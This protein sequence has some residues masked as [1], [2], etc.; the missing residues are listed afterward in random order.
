MERDIE[1]LSQSW[2]DAPDA[3][4]TVAL[5]N[6]M[7]GPVHATLIQQVGDFARNNLASNVPVLI[8]V[9]RMYMSAQR[10]SEAQGTLVTAGKLAPRD[11]AVYRVL[12]ECLLRRGDADRSEKVLE[13]AIHFGANDPETRLWLERSRVFKPMQAKAGNRAVA[14]EIERT[15]PAGTN[16]AATTSDDQPPPRAQ[17]DSFPDQ[18]TEVKE[19]QLPKAAL[20][21]PGTA[22]APGKPAP[23][24]KPPSKA[25]PPPIPGGNH[26]GTG[27]PMTT[28]ESHP[29]DA[30][31]SLGAR[32][33]TQEPATN[34]K[35]SSYSKDADTASI[36]RAALPLVDPIGHSPDENSLSFDL[37]APPP[38]AS[39]PEAVSAQSGPY[40]E[41]G[42]KGAPNPRD[43][44]DA[45]ALAGVFEPPTGVPALL[46]WDKPNI[47]QR[48][49]TSI[50]LIVMTVIAAGAMIGTF[51]YVHKKRAEQHLAS[52]T[53]LAKV[54]GELHAAK[55][56]SIAPMEQDFSHVFEIDSRSPRAAL[57]WMRE[58]A[59]VG[60]LNGGKDIAFEDATTR[61]AEV[62]LKEEQFSFAQLAGFLF[63]GDT[64]GGAAILPRYDTASAG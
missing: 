3:D 58:R 34:N 9:A 42:G 60:L 23:P 32:M 1:Q 19:R 16:G 35:K 57:D 31:A 13:R 61:A 46:Q 43:V 51:Q 2:K 62:G 15:A 54:E 56:A 20:P 63:Q 59:L 52:E 12:G 33:S 37:G 27:S 47:K 11:A 30:Q 4:T 41:A 53:I 6:A 50:A 49:R 36:A 45:L 24:L 10:L 25:A 14:A 38:A 28:G 26:I 17:M 22:K 21:P 8:S 18:P 40:R 7:R 39:R 55:P 44:L 64:A 29:S 48:R 5:C